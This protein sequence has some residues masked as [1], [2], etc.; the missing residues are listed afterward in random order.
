MPEYLS[1]G[2]YV[3]EVSFRAKFI[4]GVSTSTCGI[5]GQTSFGPVSGRPEVVTSFADFRRRYGGWEDLQYGAG[6]S[7]QTNFT[8]HAVRAFFD[9]G[10]Q[11]IYVARVFS[12]EATPG[13]GLNADGI[14]DLAL[15]GTAAARVQARY[16]GSWGNQLRVLIERTPD[17]ELKNVLDSSG[18]LRGVYPGAMVQVTPTVVDDR[19]TPLPALGTNGTLTYFVRYINGVARL[20]DAQGAPQTVTAGHGVYLV[21]LRVSV[22]TGASRTPDAVYSNLSTSAAAQS[23]IGRF[24]DLD[25]PVDPVTQLAITG[26]APP[27]SFDA[28]ALYTYLTGFTIT[29]RSLQGGN[30]GVLPDAAAYQGDETNELQ[31][32][33]MFALGQVDDISIVMAPDAAAPQGS[34]H[35]RHQAIN[36]SL[37]AHAE[38]E[39]YR[40]AILDEPLAQTSGPA[41]TFRSQY[42]SSYAG[43]YYPWVDIA[44]PRAGQDGRLLRVPPSGSVA[45]IYARTDVKRGVWKAPANEP[46]TGALDLEFHVNKGVQDVLNPRAV[47]CLRFFEEGGFRVWGART[48]SA[49]PEWKYINVR[50]LFLFLEHSIDHGTQWVVFEPNNERTWQNV[51]ATIESFLYNVWNQGALMGT[52]PEEAFFVR[53]DRTTMTQNDLDN[54]RLVC[55]I[56]VA[57]AYPAEFV[58]FRIGQWTADSKTA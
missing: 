51:R 2:V 44:D 35:T 13:D 23:F 37:I 25:S 38:H 31:P 5:V 41:L 49:D 47:N 36:N 24:F 18:T 11:R 8:A 54:G 53:C 16:P 21:E 50:R 1:P 42:D 22:F 46:V 26:I 55:L 9:N 28:I 32:T 43:I 20:V 40:F 3:E 6:T 17:R 45:G 34:S 29:A 7:T 4:E 15:P 33:G 52:K 39:R 48:L 30:D 10:G 58:I 14:A 57:P 19:T 27:A 12:P 56:G